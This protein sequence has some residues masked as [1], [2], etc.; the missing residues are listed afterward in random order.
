MN[1]RSAY[2]AVALAV[3]LLLPSSAS[4]QKDRFRDALIA[5]RASLGGT[6]G[7]EGPQLR[8]ALDDMASSLAEWD[9]EAA[10]AETEL[11]GGLPDAPPEDRLRRR[12]ALA[13]LMLDRGRWAEALVDL[14][15]AAAENPRRAFVYLA[16]GLVRDTAG[17]TT[18]AAGD[19][20]RA[21]EL[22][23]GDPIK[24]Y[25]LVT[26]GLVAGVLDDPGPPIDAL[27]AA[28][29]ARAVPSGFMEI[30][31]L[32]D[33]AEWPVFAPASY[34]EGF[35]LVAKGRYREAVESFRAAVARDPLLI[36]PAAKTE[37]LVRG[38]AKLRDGQYAAAIAHLE[39]AVAASP[40]SAE[41][42]R[43]LGTA[44][45]LAERPAE[46]LERFTTAIRLV[47][48]DERS[49]LALA[50]ELLTQKRTKEGE[51]AL[52][53][54]IAE[55]PSSAEARWALAQLYVQD[56]RSTEALRELEALSTFPMLAGRGQVDWLL[57][58]LHRRHQDVEA[59]TRVLSDRVRLDLNN[60]V[61]HKELGLAYTL[62]GSRQ[63]ALAEL[64]L[65]ALF[66]PDDV[67]TLAGIGQ[68]HLDDGR[69]SEA[70]AVLRR[71]VARAPDRAQARFA[72]G[73][74]LLRLGREEEGRA[75]LDAF[76]RLLVSKRESEH[77]K[78]ESEMQLRNAEQP[79]KQAVE[80]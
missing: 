18:G 56:D 47:P 61:V 60:P 33:R 6:F 24:A 71:V 65:T 73:T 8:A 3:A 69:Y 40:G 76:Q 7:D 19:F 5:F 64:L 32:R 31:L 21:W 15:V 74:A 42:H 30:G 63:L 77:Q 9:R 38:I 1:V 48:S 13:S 70:E 59:M 25:L 46:S 27:L 14:D 39:A 29:R 34:A 44:Y 78:V 58:Q 75:E 55:L 22:D 51:S 41:A 53:E 79:A 37:Q 16:R 36:D 2:F 28:H 4:A 35:A 80:P 50:R 17:D 54:A 45:Y 43:L 67:E 72:L 68:L 26:R 66:A 49:R 52:H 23:R 12:I 62:S 57:S 20:R 11:R 10:S